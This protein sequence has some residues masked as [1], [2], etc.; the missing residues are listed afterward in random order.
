[1]NATEQLPPCTKIVSLAAY[2]R[3]KRMESAVHGLCAELERVQTERDTLRT[4][5]ERAVADLRTGRND[6]ALLVLEGTLHQHPHLRIN[7]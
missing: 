5:V 2:A 1:M 6:S 4:A 3:G 7:R